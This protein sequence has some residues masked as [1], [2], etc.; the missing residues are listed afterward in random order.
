[1]DDHTRQKIDETRHIWEPRG[2]TVHDALEAHLKRQ[3]VEMGDYAEW[4]EPLLEFPL[5][6]RYSAIAS[7]YRLVDRR[8]RYAGSLDALVRGI[9]RDGK[10]SNVLLDLKTKS[11]NGTCGD[12]RAQLGAYTRMLNQWH[13]TLEIARCL[14]VNSFPGRVELSVY[15]VQECVD[16]W[17]QK[18]TDYCE[19]DP[20]I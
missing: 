11:A 14:V 12:H 3:P 7:E 15:T 19:W 2:N 1:M 20:V 5:W 8:G 6:N 13:S 17:D 10:W 4:I 9:D 18:W 16:A